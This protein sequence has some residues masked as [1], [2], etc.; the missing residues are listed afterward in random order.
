MNQFYENLAQQNRKRPLEG[1]NGEGST[2][3]KTENSSA[4]TS[5][6][7]KRQNATNGTKPARM[8]QKSGKPVQSQ[9]LTNAP[10]EIYYVA[11]KQLK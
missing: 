2:N 5:P 6:S 10:E 1:Q 8:T 3:G 9:N 11:N 4:D 7:S